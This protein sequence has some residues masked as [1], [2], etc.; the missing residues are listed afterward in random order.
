MRGHRWT[1]VVQAQVE[2][3]GWLDDLELW[4]FSTGCSSPCAVILTLGL[5]LCLAFPE[6][7]LSIVYMYQSDCSTATIPA[8]S[9]SSAFP[10]IYPRN[11]SNQVPPAPAA[12]STSNPDPSA[13]SP[14]ALLH[15]L[16]L[17]YL[18]D[19]GF[20]STSRAASVTLSSV[21]EK[22]ISAT[23]RACA[24]KAEHAGRRKVGALDMVHVLEERQGPGVMREM[25]EW[26]GRQEREEWAGEE[27]ERGLEGLEG[28]LFVLTDGMEAGVLVYGLRL[29]G[30]HRDA[31]IV[32][33]LGFRSE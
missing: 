24:K 20:A 16:T 32:P 14:S 22:Y 3:T 25:E 28:G 29:I 6:A 4:R 2:T 17:K 19:S 9:G 30:V 33:A 23:A 12:A 5:Y 26:V 18:S 15:L 11:M 8:A 7:S 31:D 13:P 21:L 1:D 27:W 10:Y